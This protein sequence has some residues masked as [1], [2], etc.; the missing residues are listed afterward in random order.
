MIYCAAFASLTYQPRSTFE[1]LSQNMLVNSKNGL[2]YLT[3]K[4][5][6]AATDY[7]LYCMS[8]TPRGVQLSLANALRQVAHVR[9][10]CCKSITVSLLASSVYERKSIGDAVS[11][12][13]NGPPSS[14]LT[15]SAAFVST[16]GTSVIVT[17]SANVESTYAY[18]SSVTLTPSSNFRTAQLLRLVAGTQDTAV[19]VV[20]LSGPS[21]DEYLLEYA[22]NR[23]IVNILPLIVEP[24]LPV[25]AVAR[26]SDDGS[27]V[28]LTFDSPTDKARYSNAFS[29]MSLLSFDGA[30]TAA[31]QWT[32]SATILVFPK[33]TGPDS[34]A[35]AVG[36]NVTL[37]ADQVRA[38]CVVNDSRACTAWATVPLTR[39]AVRAPVNPTTPV[40]NFPLPSAVSACNS[41]VIDLTAS[42]GT[43][44]RPWDSLTFKVLTSNGETVATMLL[45]KFLDANYTYS[46]PTV[47][48]TDIMAPGF[49]YS[50]QATVCNFLG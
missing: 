44:G 1:I 21:A 24:T 25:L 18:P 33:Y 38:R 11:I 23:R 43:A 29:C 9:T 26:F 37:F 5:L 34:N 14:T 39:V 32:S 16:S 10:E 17:N 13:I 47:V 45:Q 27:A 2:A 6:Y 8:V 46:P 7:S 28:A 30:A 36:S 19:L 20:T 4:S 48:P 35:L 15:I 12:A 50:I 41:L 22:E 3:V 42:S 40:V 31:C 49:I